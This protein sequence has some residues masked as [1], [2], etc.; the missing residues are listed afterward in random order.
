ME[1]YSYWITPYLSVSVSKH[2]GIR[3]S[4]LTSFGQYLARL[5]WE[6]QQQ[7]A[8]APSS[9]Q[10]KMNISTR[11]YFSLKLRTSSNRTTCSILIRSTVALK[12][13]HNEGR[14]VDLPHQSP[15]KGHWQLPQSCRTRES[16]RLPLPPMTFPHSHDHLQERR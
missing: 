15:P 11:A 1:S 12:V 2:R 7:I 16:R 6:K 3:A 10:Q 4:L 14:Q 8:L 13:P 5:I 9:A